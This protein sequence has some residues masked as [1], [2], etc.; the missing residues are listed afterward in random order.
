M[1]EKSTI[2][3][4]INKIGKGIRTDATD[5]DKGVIK[6]AGDLS[7]TAYLPK[8][9]SAHFGLNGYYDT[10]ANGIIR[11]VYRDTDGW[12]RTE[13]VSDDEAFLFGTLGGTIV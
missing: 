2:K 9:V 6:L 7:G 5:T 4:T 12:P 1:G 13:I 11:R 3:L 8:V 10:D